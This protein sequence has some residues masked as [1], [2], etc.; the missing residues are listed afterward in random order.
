MFVALG[1]AGCSEKAAKKAPS[2]AAAVQDKAPASV[3]P[4]DVPVD[5]AFLIAA[6]EDSGL[7]TEGCA[8]VGNS[9]KTALKGALLAKMSKAPADHAPEL[10]HYYTG[11]EIQAIMGWVETSSSECGL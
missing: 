11:A 5:V 3:P 2:E 9:A 6:C 4:A 1:A 7:P 10:E 8:C